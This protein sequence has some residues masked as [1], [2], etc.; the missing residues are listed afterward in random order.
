M[1][2]TWDED[3]DPWIVKGVTRAFENDWFGIDAHDVIRPDG[4]PGQ[5]GVIRVRRLAVGVLPIEADG[6]VHMVGQWRFPLGRYSWE[7]P[8]G[9][10]EPGEDA[11]DCAIREL[12]EETGVRAQ[13]L[14]KV[15][16]MDLSNSLTDEKA[17]IFIATDLAPG[18]A[19]PEATEVLR[20]R[21]A[22][23]RDVLARVADGRI[24]D[25][26]TVAAVLRAHHMAVTGQLPPL[27]AEEMLRQGD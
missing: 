10:G 12:A 17:V 13:T 5:Y 15:L 3:G 20:H 25:S 16:E 19:E 11:H 14:L 24:R 7:M 4:R 18:D 26:L 8:E 22:H 23:F 27:L 1:S 6:R 2:E 21:T 9:G